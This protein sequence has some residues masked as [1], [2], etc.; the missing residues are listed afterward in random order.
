M[1]ERARPTR[2]THD[3]A[4]DPEAV[5]T[6]LGTGTSAGVPLIGCGCDTCTSDD[7][8][9]RRLRTAAMLRF[10]DAG[11]VRGGL[12]GARTWTRESSLSTPQKIRRSRK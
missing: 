5:L 3:G 8:R 2:S 4:R 11:G 10:L 6:L 12:K 1:A 7:P 9:D